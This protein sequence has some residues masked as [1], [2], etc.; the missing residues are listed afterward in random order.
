MLHKSDARA[1][2]HTEV[3]E[4]DVARHHRGLQRSA[5]SSRGICSDQSS[6]P[7]RVMT[8]LARAMTSLARVMASILLIWIR[9]LRPARGA[10]HF[11][12]F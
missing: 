11:V 9:G 3:R 1:D 4:S 2:V 12:A 7:A 10:L 5:W 8:S 6:L